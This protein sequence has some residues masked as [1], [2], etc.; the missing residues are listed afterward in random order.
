[1]TVRA[2]FWVK[3]IQHHHVSSPLET[4]AEVALAPVYGNADTPNGQWSKY[5]PQGEI[6][7]TITNPDAVAA[8]DLGKAY[9]VD[10]SP[11]D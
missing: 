8:F 4:C 6:K 5:T 10:F 9:Y 1:M 3:S 7:M 2:K 11:A